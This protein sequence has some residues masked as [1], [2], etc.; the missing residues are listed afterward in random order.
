MKAVDEDLAVAENGIVGCEVG[1][2]KIWIF[3]QTDRPNRRK[4]NN[5]VSFS[6]TQQ[7]PGI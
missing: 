7:D 1:E 5:L 2:E 6:S 3:A 4:K